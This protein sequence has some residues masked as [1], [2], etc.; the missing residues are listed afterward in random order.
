MNKIPELSSSLQPILDFEM[1]R[2]NRVERVDKPAGSNCPLAVIFSAPL[3]ISEYAQKYGLPV[4]V[5]TWENKDKHYP[6]EAGYFCE[7]TH[8]AIS[9]PLPR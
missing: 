9:G 7:R 2:G 6:L 4:G 1:G 5:R 3:G 8:H